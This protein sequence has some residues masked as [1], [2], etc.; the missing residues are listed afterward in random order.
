MPKLTAYS[1]ATFALSLSCQDDAATAFDLTGYTAR[2]SVRQSLTSATVTLDLSPTIPSPATGVIEINIADETTAAI[3]PGNYVWD[4]VLD[5]PGGG[6]V[7]L[8]GGSLIL[9]PL[10]TQ[11]S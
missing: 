1:G 6:V 2:G 7:Y 11:A 10:A 8:V 5:E 4:V 9:R 3:D